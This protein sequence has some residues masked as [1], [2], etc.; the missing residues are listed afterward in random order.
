MVSPTTVDAADRV[1]GNWYN[2]VYD[3]VHIVSSRKT[4]QF[5]ELPMPGN[6]PTFPSRRQTLD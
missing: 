3:G 6:Y 5:P 1:G 2:G 4:T